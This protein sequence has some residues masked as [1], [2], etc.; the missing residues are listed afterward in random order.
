MTRKNKK[1]AQQEPKATVKINGVDVDPGTL[2]QETQEMLFHFKTLS[3][4]EQETVIELCHIRAAK[5]HYKTMLL[6]K[7]PKPE[8]G[9]S[10]Q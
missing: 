2:D 8:E 5:E 7:I 6:E 3:E 9:V 1:P 10:I 4:K